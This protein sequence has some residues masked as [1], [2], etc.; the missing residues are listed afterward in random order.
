[1][2]KL[3]TNK[4][5]VSKKR[6]KSGSNPIAKKSRLADE[7][8]FDPNLFNFDETIHNATA[9]VQTSENES[10]FDGLEDK[11]D[12][13][14]FG[15]NGAFSD[16][17][18]AFSGNLVNNTSSFSVS[19]AV[20]PSHEKVQKLERQSSLVPIEETP[21]LTRSSSIVFASEEQ[22]GQDITEDEISNLVTEFFGN[23]TEENKFVF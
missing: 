9:N 22:E 1:M 8:F 23:E 5:K 13:E 11:N 20:E 18:P 15:Q 7:L 3:K 2:A 12:F 21:E 6:K 10:L 16:L 14:N 17:H 19:F 4:K